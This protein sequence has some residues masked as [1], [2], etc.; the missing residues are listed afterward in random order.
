MEGLL[1]YF[2]RFTEFY[3]NE[4]ENTEDLQLLIQH[5]LE[6]FA[7]SGC[8]VSGIIRYHQRFH[9]VIVIILLL[10]VDTVC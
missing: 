1:F 8:D 6:G 3:V 9:R 4:L 2:R 7:I 5:Y 10:L